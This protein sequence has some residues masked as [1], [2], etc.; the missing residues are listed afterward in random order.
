MKCSQCGC[1]D[2]VEVEFPQK[3][4]LILTSVGIA[5]ESNFYE[6]ENRVDCNSYI[7]LNCGHFEF[8]SSMM[9]EQIKTERKVREEVE[10]N[11]NR[12]QNEIIELRNNSSDKYKEIDKLKLEAQDLDI[13]LRRNNEIQVLISN[14]END[15]ININKIIVKK[16]QEIIDLKNTL[17]S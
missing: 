7:C 11:I 1:A 16:K 12:I 6:I 10:A 13:T 2:L 9:A 14:L 3:T 5:G 15:I 8:F 17:N 4:S